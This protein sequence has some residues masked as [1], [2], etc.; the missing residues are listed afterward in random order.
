MSRTGTV[1]STEK[2]GTQTAVVLRGLGEVREGQHLRR[3]DQVWTVVKKRWV[4]KP[5]VSLILNQVRG[6]L[7]VPEVDWELEVMLEPGDGEAAPTAVPDLTVETVVRSSKSTLVCA[8]GILPVEAGDVVVDGEQAWKV[9]EVSD[10]QP[11]HPH[12]VWLS[13]K[14]EKGTQFD[15]S[16][17]SRLLKKA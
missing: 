11:A 15:P 1:A 13:I 3:G 16:P 10:G 6:E 2:V 5:H 17:N 4:R 14:A 8:R 9:L 7:A 12:K